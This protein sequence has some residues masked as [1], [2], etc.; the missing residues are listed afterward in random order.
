MLW[1]N[2][3]LILVAVCILTGPLLRSADEGV[4]IGLV[5]DGL[6]AE[7]R[8]PLR[9]YLSKTLGRPVKLAVPDRYAETL[10]LLENGT[11]DLIVKE[12]NLF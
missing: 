2:R 6:T 4:T 11:Y 12:L 1:R 8:A 5:P 7:D 10:S 3:L 9:D